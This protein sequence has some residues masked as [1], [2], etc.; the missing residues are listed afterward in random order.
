MSTLLFILWFFAPA[1]LANTAPVFVAKIKALERFSTPLDLHKKYRNKRIFGDH[2]TVRGLLA[3][4][5]IGALT[6][7]IQVLLYHN[8]SWAQSIS[9]NIDYSGVLTVLMGASMGFGALFGDAIES[10]FKRQLSIPSGHSW[11]PFD[12]LDYILG[13]LLFSLPFITLSV[14]QYLILAFLWFIL[15]PIITVIGWKLKLRDSPI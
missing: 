14:M 6:A 7:L 11:F 2:K 4:I 5:A 3:G 12:Q 8:F 15:H 9:L 13:G 10:F 1:G